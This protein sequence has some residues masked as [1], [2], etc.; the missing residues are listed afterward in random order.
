MRSQ[1]LSID[2]L[3]TDPNPHT[4][5]SNGGL[6]QADNIVI[7]RAGVAEPRPG[8]KAA[9]YSQTDYPNR[10][11]AWD[12]DILFMGPN[13]TEWSDGTDVLTAESSAAVTFST[14]GAR[15]AA[16]RDNLYITASDRVR[17]LTSST[18]ATA[19]VAGLPRVQM[20]KIQL[21]TGGGSTIA[22]N[23]KLAYRPVLRRTDDNGVIVRSA[24][25]AR[26]LLNRTTAGSSLTV[27]LRANWHVLD[28]VRA[29]DVLEFYRSR[30]VAS[31][32]TPS[33][34]LFLAVE[35][36]LTSTDATTG[37]VSLQDGDG[38]DPSD[39][40]AAL[41]T[42]PSR[43]G[44]AR[45]NE[46][47]PLA[48]DIVEFQGSL[49]AARVTYPH[50]LRLSNS[51]AETGGS[52]GADGTGMRSRTGVRTN[53]SNQITNMSGTT[54]IKPG[55][56]L[57][58]SSWTGTSQPW[59]TEVFT[60]TVVMSH[61]WGGS[62]DGAPIAQQFWD[63]IRIKQGGSSAF[64]A[65][66]TD[67]IADI[68]ANTTL[69]LRAVPVG[70][71]VEMEDNTVTGTVTADFV[72][73]GREPSAAVFE[74]FATHGSEYEPKIPEPFTAATG[75]TLTSTGTSSI[76][77]AYA[78]GLAWT[79][80]HEPEHWLLAGW[81]SVGNAQLPIYKLV[82]TRDALF[83][84]KPDGIWRLSGFGE[85]SGWRVDEF[86]LSHRAVAHDAYAVMDDTI[87]T[88]SD[89]GLVAVSDGGVQLISEPT[90]ANEIRR[91]VEYLGADS[92]GSTAFVGAW[93]CANPKAHE[94]LFGL[95]DTNEN[96]G[97]RAI[98]DE[99]ARNVWVYNT[100]TGA[101]VRWFPDAEWDLRHMIT[102]ESNRLV[103]LEE[104][105][106]I[107]NTAISTAYV[108][109]ET[110]YTAEPDG[111]TLV[112]EQ[113][114]CDREFSTTHVVSQA[115]TNTILVGVTNSTWTVQ[116]GDMVHHRTWY[117]VI[118]AVSAG[119][120]AQTKT[121][122]FTGTQ[123]WTTGTSAAV[124][125]YQSFPCTIRW[126]PKV[127]SGPGELKRFRQALYHF[128]DLAGVAEWTAKFDSELS[129]VA[130]S[131]AYSETYQTDATR[132][133]ERRALVPRN[134]AQTTQLFPQ[135]VIRQAGGRWKLTGVTLDYE[136]VGGR[137]RR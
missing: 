28:D 106:P 119:T 111:S 1:H 113:Y 94:V 95:P 87:Y 112:A 37:S 81:Q 14:S 26:A 52:L 78:N 128:E 56:V 43:E 89:R 42:N 13:K 117:D 79:K 17:K 45:A 72:L 11:H 10:M 7:R 114:H 53:A 66:G 104:T 97:V 77:T 80:R 59:V 100:S 103:I 15:A 102:D 48:E 32:Q 36:E 76:Q 54:G 47:P 44:I 49:F 70:T 124:T 115:S 51:F 68:D 18:D 9:G 108:E 6:K 91:F 98:N 110:F 129:S 65:V 136:S 120:S 69:N 135:V 75:G 131:T 93:A 21:G 109:R 121:L 130:S 101:W 35:Y 30:A 133:T 27:T 22:S 61:S 71:Y 12:G 83:I 122:A 39:L 123:D 20:G 88:I 55:A 38:V 116:A 33:D 107:E 85:R 50:S 2:G 40:G 29:G 125:I 5:T 25:G 86:D 73:Q 132:V 8:F 3:Q 24:P 134:H 31:T 118:T 19:D 99:W 16:S 58:Q 127:G 74:T 60:N 90:I 126:T 105:T 96:V 63:S 64:F 137:V 84:F 4:K 82:P 62:T 67:L 92:A 57:Q 41:Y 46:M 23:Q 34:E